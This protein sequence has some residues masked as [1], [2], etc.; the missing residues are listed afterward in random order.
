MKRHIFLIDPLEKLV[1][2]K[3]STLMLALTM[4][5]KGISCFVLFEKDFYY[6]NLPD[7]TLTVQN[8][9][10]EFKDDDIYLQN[11]EIEESIE[12]IPSL[13]DV[14]HMR[15]DPPFDGRYLRTLWALEGLK[16]RGVKVTNDPRGILI[17]NEK[18][19]AYRHPLSLN[20]YLGQCEKSFLRFCDK[21]RRE[22]HENIILKPIDLYQ[23]MGVQ[24]VNLNA[25][26]LCEKFVAMTKDYGGM[27]VVQPFEKS[28]QQ[29][30]IRSFYFDGDEIGSIIK[31]P[32][33]GEFLANIAQGASFEKIVLPRE[34]AKV[35]AEICAD[36]A[37]YGI[38]WVAF[39]I[40]GGKISEVN[41][42]CPGLLV[43]VSK[44]VGRNLSHEIIS[45]MDLKS[46]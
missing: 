45:R 33:E 19:T 20:S 17:F 13:G 31:R 5:Q 2:K 40:L 18:L 1:I 46:P 36:L 8:F 35:C 26:D 11:F 44:A 27:V 43:E 37:C 9:R 14:V 42:T 4:K 30:E 34:V 28:V 6:T 16:D 7:Y 21:L 3:D 38:R 10:G 22:G 41:I 24:K 23:G 39:D 12:I 32:K 29:G 25:T 15:F